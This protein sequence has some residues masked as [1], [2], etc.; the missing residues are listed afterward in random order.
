M[1]FSAKEA[2][3]AATFQKKRQKEQED[4]QIKKKKIEEELQVGSISNKFAAHYDAIEQ[5]LRS[6]TIG[7]VTLDEMRAK[8]EVMIKERETQLAQ[9]DKES[10]LSK[11]ELKKQKAKDKAQKGALSFQFEDEEEEDSGEEEPELPQKKR[12]GMNPDVD[13]SFLP[14]REREEE[15]RILRAKLAAEWMQKQEDI[16]NE[17]ITVTYSYWD[18]KGHRR[19][20]TMKKGNSIYQFLQRSLENLRKE[21]VYAE[22][23]VASADQLMY[24]KEDLIL[25]H[26][27][28]FFEFIVTKARG[29]SGPLF[30][31]DVQEDVRI[32]SDAAVEKNESHAGKVVMR[33]WY[34]R[35]KHIFPACRW[36]VFDPEKKW[37]GYSISDKEKNKF[38]VK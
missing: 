23:K 10:R 11:A 37:D 13:T 9:K 7:L 34:E 19:Q 3:R 31:F 14:D 38:T 22:L 28:T 4:L 36:E 18:G 25:P 16:K 1:A 2:H 21:D 6:D 12:L 15:E 35:H 33:T 29:K 26:H 24:V 27:S 32:K 20:T 30:N 17:E 8:Q 5:Q